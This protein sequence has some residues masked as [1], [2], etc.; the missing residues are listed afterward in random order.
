KST[1]R[2]LPSIYEAVIVEGEAT[3]ESE[4][5]SLTAEVALHLSDSVVRT[6]GMSSTE[7]I[8]RG[9]EVIATGNSISVPVGD[10]TLGRVFNVLGDHIDLGEDVAEG[11]QFDPIHRQAPE[12]EELATET[13][14][15]ETGIKVVDLL[16]PY[17]K[18][19]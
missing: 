8:S 6:I 13:E 11:T 5:R 19:G 4:A 14:V 1:E 12:F 15:L 2:N 16:A 18:G 3:E 10:A 9:T 17:I 7:G